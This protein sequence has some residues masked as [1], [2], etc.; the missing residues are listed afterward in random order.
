MNRYYFDASALVKRYAT[1]QGTDLVL[2]LLQRA[3]NVY[4][5]SVAYAELIIA[6]RRKRDEGT[7]QGEQLVQLLRDL[8]TEWEGL[9]RVDL[10]DAVLHLVRDNCRFYPLRALDAVHLASALFLR[11][12]G[13]AFEFVC[14]DQR[15]K[16][17]ASTEG[18]DVIDP[19]EVEGST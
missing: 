1:E 8:D 18:F 6:F 11:Q 13:M 3:A 9:D 2:A 7:L 14:S 15:L 16:D 4:I 5:A 10:T 17:A 19:A 12:E